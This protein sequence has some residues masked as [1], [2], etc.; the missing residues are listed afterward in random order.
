M[1]KNTIIS[2][3]ALLLSLAALIQINLRDDTDEELIKTSVD[4]ALKNRELAFVH[5]YKPK[6]QAMISGQIFETH[7]EYGKEWNPKT[8]EELFEPINKLINATE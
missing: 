3:L 6:I 1:K 4:L 2:V 7:E 5:S 8:L